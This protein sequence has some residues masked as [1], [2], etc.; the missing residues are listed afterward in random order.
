MIEQTTGG[1]DNNV[2]SLANATLL[3]LALLSSA[4]HRRDNPEEGEKQFLDRFLD[5]NAQLT[6]WNEDDAVST[7]RAVDLGGHALQCLDNGD[8]IGQ[9]LSRSGFGLDHHISSLQNLGNGEGLR[10]RGLRE[11]KHIGTLQ[12]LRLD[13]IRPEENQTYHLFTDLHVREGLCGKH[14]LI[15]EKLQGIGQTGVLAL[16]RSSSF[17]GVL[18]RSYDSKPAEY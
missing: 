2:C 7:V 17:Y 15:R 6:R 5:L 8:Q 16:L 3:R 1:G 4:N 11:S 10:N 9:G 12:H 14:V 13:V 18:T